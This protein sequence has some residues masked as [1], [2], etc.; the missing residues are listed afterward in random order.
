MSRTLRKQT[1]SMRGEPIDF[2][3]LTA[4]HETQRTLGN[5]NTNVRGDQLGDRGIILKTQ[6]QVQA[7]RDRLAALQQGVTQRAAVKQQVNTLAP[8]AT[9]SFPTLQD[10]VKDGAIPPIN[11]KSKG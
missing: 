4:A 5:A 2:A 3:A 11:N 6:E 8:D 9:V 1:L 7:E 10:L